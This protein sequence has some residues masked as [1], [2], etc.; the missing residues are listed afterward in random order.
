MAGE[1]L[2]SGSWPRPEVQPDDAGEQPSRLRR[3]AC[4]LMRFSMALD[5]T[6]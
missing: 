1:Q 5:L 4:T 3:E 6:I 2:A